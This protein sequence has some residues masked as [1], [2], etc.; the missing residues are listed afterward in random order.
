MTAVGRMNIIMKV[1]VSSEKMCMTA[2]TIE[3][4]FTNIVI[5]RAYNF[6]LTMNF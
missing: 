4:H 2:H 3:M 1:S 5:F 6:R